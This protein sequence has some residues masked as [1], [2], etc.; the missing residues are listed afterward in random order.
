MISKFELIFKIAKEP[1]QFLTDKSINCLDAF[2]LGFDA[3]LIFHGKE[4]SFGQND[5]QFINEWVFNELFVTEEHSNRMN[6][7][8]CVSPQSYSELITNGEEEAFDQY[9]KIHREAY[10]AKPKHSEHAEKDTL[11]QRDFFKLIESV[12]KRP[13]MYVME[14]DIAAYENIAL[15]FIYAEERIIKISSSLG[16][17]LSEFKSWLDDR[18]PYGGGIHFSKVIKFT[19][20]GQRLSDIEYFEEHLGMF[21]NNEASDSPDRTNELM[22]KNI[23][24]HAEKLKE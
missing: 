2:I 9:I 20:M 19:S 13:G 21:R 8:N 18:Y 22:I 17:E 15:G 23:L 6:A 3:G 7:F 16:K 10:I 12:K 11:M 4:T 14:W 5:K 24:E 1:K